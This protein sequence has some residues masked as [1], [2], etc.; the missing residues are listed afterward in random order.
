MRAP[1][2]TR[3]TGGMPTDLP[4]DPRHDP[5]RRPSTLVWALFISII[6][7]LG[8]LALLPMITTVTAVALW[9]LGGSGS[10]K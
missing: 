6:V 10:N 1:G 7:I 4:P 5:P 9:G 8:F 3:L 2:V